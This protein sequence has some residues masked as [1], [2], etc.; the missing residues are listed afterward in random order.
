MVPKMFVQAD[1]TDDLR[2]LRMP[3]LVIAG[4]Q[5]KPFLGDVERIAGAIPGAELVILS[6]AGHSPQF[7]NTDAWWHALT[8]F[9]GTV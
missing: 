4:E 1:R 9:L 2:A 8:S 6:D 3:A 7:E 5:D